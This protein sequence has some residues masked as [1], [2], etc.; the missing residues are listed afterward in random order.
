M[1]GDDPSRDRYP[2]SG[3]G[4]VY[5]DLISHSRL[6]RRESTVD[7]TLCVASRAAD[8][9][10]GINAHRSQ[11]F[12][13]LPSPAG[14]RSGVCV[15]VSYPFPL[16]FISSSAIRRYTPPLPL[17][18]FATLPPGHLS[19][20]GSGAPRLP[21]PASF[22]LSFRLSFASFHPRS[23]RPRGYATA[24]LTNF[25]RGTTAVLATAPGTQRDYPPWNAR[26]PNYSRHRARESSSSPCRAPLS[27]GFS[28]FLIFDSR[29][30]SNAAKDN[31]PAD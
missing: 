21:S 10:G 7:V 14:F 23:P 18:F 4:E 30:L 12:N 3:S 1:P 28:I 22:A 6:T 9:G 20:P 31:C 5:G 8:P 16:L 2:R 25:I 27:P 13:S 26:S 24:A 11:L 17:A 19:P 29:K 15:C